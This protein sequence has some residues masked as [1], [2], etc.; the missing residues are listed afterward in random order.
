MVGA[1]LSLKV[2]VVG[3]TQY[4]SIR[5]AASAGDRELTRSARAPRRVPPC[6]SNPAN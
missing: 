5:D 3:A 1:P 4:S 2:L 6:F